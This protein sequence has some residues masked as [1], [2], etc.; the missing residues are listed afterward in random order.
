MDPVWHPGSHSG[1][2]PVHRDGSDHGVRNTEGFNH[3][4][5]RSIVVDLLLKRHIPPVQGQQ[6]VQFTNEMELGSSHGTGL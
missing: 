3:V 1:R 5:D 6:I 4:L 2:L